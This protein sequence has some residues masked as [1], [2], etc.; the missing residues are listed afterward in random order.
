MIYILD[1]VS[2]GDAYVTGQL[3]DKREFKNG[4][5]RDTDLVYHDS[6]PAL[7]SAAKKYGMCEDW[8]NPPFDR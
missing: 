5:F 4:T 3:Y 8:P 1:H 6:R 7:G 2:S